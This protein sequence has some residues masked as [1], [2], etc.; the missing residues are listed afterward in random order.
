[1]KSKLSLFLLIFL[2]PLF[3]LFSSSVF[4]E[5]IKEFGVRLRVFQNADLNVSET[6][7]Y[8]FGVEEKHGIFREIPLILTNQN[9]EKFRLKIE[10]LFVPNWS[11]STN[12]TNLSLTIKIGDANK[13]VSGE[14]KYHIGY[15]VVGGLRYFSDHD[16]IYWNV[17]G[18]DW[19]VSINKTIVAVELPAGVLINKVTCYTGAT[20]SV[21]TNCTSSFEQN[22]A[23]FSTNNLNPGEGLTI[24]VSLPKNMIAVVEPEKIVPWVPPIWLIVLISLIAL[25]YYLFLPLFL[26]RKWFREGRDPQTG[27]PAVTFDPPNGMR[28]AE[29]GTLVD[30]SA[31]NRDI[32]ATIVDLAI[33]KYLKIKQ[34]E[35]DNYLLLKQK[36]ADQ[37]LKSYEK[38]IFKEIFSEGKDVETKDLADF[39]LVSSAVKDDLYEKLTTD[40]LFVENPQKQRNKYYLLAGLAI[41]T[42]NIF[43]ALVSFLFGKNMPRKTLDGAKANQQAQGLKIFLSS[44][45]RQLEFQAKNW[46]FFE[47]LLPYAIVFNCEK[48][49]AKR[50]KDLQATPP[51]WYEATSG[52]TFNSVIFANSLSSSLNSLNSLSLSPTTSSSGFSSGFSGGSSGGGG[53]GGGGGSW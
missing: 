39:Y 14:Q 47:K 9:N 34:L 31:D 27:N 33:K 19:D 30:E 45:G 32:S 28:P 11:N 50:F 6:I 46:Y 18:N 3:P 51:D 15:K 24:V 17:T 44:Q 29:V 23:S 37:T 48:V 53:G 41:F 35:K 49:W 21:Q 25:I 16:E 42:G 43:L 36:E 40:G 13:L 12:E 8:D 38:K 1:M 22:L 4:A 10:N 5:E 2:I 7:L 20:G 26:I 52:S